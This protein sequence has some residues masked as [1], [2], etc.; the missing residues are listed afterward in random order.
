[1]NHPESEVACMRYQYG[2]TYCSTAVTRFR[3]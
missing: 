1:M 2:R 3:E